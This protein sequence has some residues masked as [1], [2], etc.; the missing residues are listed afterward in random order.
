MEKEKIKKPW[1]SF[2]IISQGQGFKIKEIT[3][4]PQKRISLQ[5]HKQRRECW[6]VVNGQ[7]KVIK[8]QQ[9]LNL[10]KGETVF[11]EKEEIH[12]LENRGQD[13][14]EIIEIQLGNYLEEDD[15]ERLEDDFNRQ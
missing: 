13:N 2:R 10:E 12:R 1:G 11:I 3:V 6:L 9:E 4:L 7:A 14:L 15:I 5:K 8:G